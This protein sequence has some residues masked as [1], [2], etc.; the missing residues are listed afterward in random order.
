MKQSLIAL[1]TVYADGGTIYGP[2]QKDGES[3]FTDPETAETL[4]ARGVARKDHAEERA[5]PPE[6]KPIKPRK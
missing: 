6:P 5:E 1:Q 4:I 2:G 3:F